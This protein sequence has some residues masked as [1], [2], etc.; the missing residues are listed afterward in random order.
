MNGFV[1]ATRWIVHYGHQRRWHSHESM[2]SAPLGGSTNDGTTQLSFPHKKSR[3]DIFWE[4]FLTWNMTE[5]EPGG[6]AVASA[7]STEIC[8]T[9]TQANDLLKIVLKT[10]SSVKIF[11]SEQRA[12]RF[13]VWVELILQMRLKWKVIMNKNYLQNL[14][15]NGW[16]PSI[17]GAT[18]T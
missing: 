14:C 13:K 10:P 16:C 8:Q 18:G 1:A 3:F 11:V 6:T 15:T 12:E 5:T 4:G 7:I 17:L 9:W 2:P